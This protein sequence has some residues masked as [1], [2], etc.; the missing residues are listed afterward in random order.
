MSSFG[1]NGIVTTA[2]GSGADLGY[3]VAIQ[4]DNK[5]VVAGYSNNGLSL[6]HI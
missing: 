2:I 3:S 4:S 5:I 6:I 1:T